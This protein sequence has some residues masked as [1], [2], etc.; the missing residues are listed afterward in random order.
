MPGLASADPHTVTTLSIIRMNGPARGGP[1]AASAKTDENTTMAE[2]SAVERL[3]EGLEPVGDGKEAEESLSRY[4]KPVELYNIIQRRAMR[5]PLFLQRCLNY[6]I[7]AARQ[8]RIQMTVSVLGCGDDSGELCLY[9]PKVNAR[10]QMPTEYGE[11][12]F[13]PVFVMVTSPVGDFGPKE[14][15]YRLNQTRVVRTSLIS[16][17]CN[18][19]G[20][21]GVTFLLPEVRKLLLSASKDGHV[22]L[23]VLFADPTAVYKDKEYNAQPLEKCSGRVF[24]GKLL[25][26]KLCKNWLSN[27]RSGTSMV[28]LNGKRVDV[29]SDVDLHHG[30]LQHVDLADG[31]GIKL[32]EPSSKSSS[33]SRSLLQ[34]YITGEEVGGKLKVPGLL[35]NGSHA[36]SVFPS[37]NRRPRYGRVVFHYLYHFNTLRKTEVTEEFSCPFC[38]VHCSSFKGLRCH[39]N[40]SHDLF[41]FEYL[42][43]DG[44]QVVNVTCRNDLLG[45]EGDQGDD[46]DVDGLNDTRIKN[47]IYKS[48]CGASRRTPVDTAKEPIDQEVSTSQLPG[49]QGE[50]LAKTCQTHGLNSMDSRGFHECQED[51]NSELKDVA[52]LHSSATGVSIRDKNR[53]QQLLQNG[54]LVATDMGRPCARTASNLDSQEMKLHETSEEQ[55][56]TKVWEVLQPGEDM[57]TRV[58]NDQNANPI[59]FGD[60]DHPFPPQKKLRSDT[61]LP[62]QEHISS[63]VNGLPS[64]STNGLCASAVAAVSSEECALS[65]V[66]ASVPVPVPQLEKGRKVS[67]QRAEARSRAQLTKRQFFHSHTAQPMALE[68]LL[69]DKDSED[70]IDDFVAD[71]EDRRMLD[72]F[73]DVTKHEKE[74]MHM[75]NSFVRKQRVLADG[76]CAWAC[77]AFSNLHAQNFQKNPTMRRCLML[78]M[79]KLWNHHLIDGKT[80]DRCLRIVDS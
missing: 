42:A 3:E 63:S 35:Q 38:L 32:V 64:L 70:E 18:G 76:H 33:P 66:V 57:K 65:A 28:G 39:L 7:E 40:A 34:V 50:V 20:E 61:L 27:P 16:S 78:F 77:E 46:S 48:R 72:D 60:M 1:N 41:N 68:Q 67:S 13:W 26:T 14:S 45:P 2:P 30:S 73:V 58:E 53:K 31:R 36:T 21:D 37:S 43:A 54:D 74:V 22:V 6:K 52:Q 51:S 29:V 59:A 62:D 17:S 4:C 25:M 79:I 49:Y 47:F 75:W 8:R 56:S 44:F 9:S 80:I 71:F 11:Q 15:V 55:K 69:S 19:N 5:H 12:Q 10:S 24:W 23:F